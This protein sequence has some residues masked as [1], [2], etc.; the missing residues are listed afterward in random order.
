MEWFEE[1]KQ[2][3]KAATFDDFNLVLMA[4]SP[5]FFKCVMKSLPRLFAIVEG[6]EWGATLVGL[7]LDATGI[8]DITKEPC[9][10]ICRTPEN[11]PHLKICSYSD[12]WEGRPWKKNSIS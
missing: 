9:C 11:Y 5:T 7:P 8:K 2:N 6:A 4:H 12:E 3:Y 10:P 1:L